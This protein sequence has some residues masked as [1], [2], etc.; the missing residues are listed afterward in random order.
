MNFAIAGSEERRL[1]RWFAANASVS[2]EDY[3][4]II[5]Q[6]DAR[7]IE[8]LEEFLHGTQW[9]IGLIDRDGILAAEIQ[10]KRFMMRHR[11]L[12]GISNEDAAVL[13]QMLGGY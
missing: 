1:L 5:L 9:R 11:W 6:E 13:E 3:R 8:V 2:G 4:D 7:K 10:V 12:L